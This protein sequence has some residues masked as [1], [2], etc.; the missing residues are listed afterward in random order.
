V[1]FCVFML[2]L[3]PGKELYIHT[4]KQ[5]ERKSSESVV[6]SVCVV[7]VEPRHNPHTHITYIH[8]Y[9][10]KREENKR[11]GQKTGYRV[12]VCFLSAF[13]LSFRLCVSVGICFYFP[14]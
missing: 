7:V 11:E 4:G 6:L 5:K 14:F 1:H 12:L 2:L 9:I 3:A 13:F 10:K 8:R